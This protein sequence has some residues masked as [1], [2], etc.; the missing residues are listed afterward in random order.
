[1]RRCLDEAWTKNRKQGFLALR[2]A[3]INLVLDS[4]AGV[5]EAQVLG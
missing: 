5:R 1:M 2:L 3:Y 4:G